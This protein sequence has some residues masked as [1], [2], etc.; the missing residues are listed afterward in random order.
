MAKNIK[1]FV[2]SLVIAVFINQGCVERKEV[3]IKTLPITTI[4]VSG[5]VVS[6]NIKDPSSPTFELKTE[7]NEKISIIIDPSSTFIWKDGKVARP[8][9]IKK[10]D[11]ISLTYEMK[12]NKKVAKSIRVEE[13]YSKKDKK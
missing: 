8:S 4:S 9:N 3:S 11:V 6:I 12:D 1:V 7:Q 13:K 10:G 2:I 5:S